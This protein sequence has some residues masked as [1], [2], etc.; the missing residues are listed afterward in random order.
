MCTRPKIDMQNNCRTDSTSV[1]IVVTCIGLDCSIFVYTNGK[2]VRPHGH[3]PMRTT[4]GRPFIISF[5][6]WHWWLTL[7]LIYLLILDRFI[8]AQMTTCHWE[9][10]SSE[11]LAFMCMAATQ[12]FCRFSWPLITNVRGS[13]KPLSYHIPPVY[14]HSV[15]IHA[16]DNWQITKA[17]LKGSE[18]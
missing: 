7:V 16:S 4:P 10:D 14:I 3:R 9:G 17:A 12:M 11:G 8:N 6:T 2:C 5:P 13:Q 15:S 18:W 1:Y